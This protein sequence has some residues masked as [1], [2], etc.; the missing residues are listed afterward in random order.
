MLSK[1]DKYMMYD[2]NIIQWTNNIFDNNRETHKIFKKP[3]EKQEKKII[4]TYTKID[5]NDPL[6]MSFFYLLNGEF[7]YISMHNE[8]ST[9]KLE[10]INL[11]DKL[12]ANKDI[13]KKHKFKLNIIED[14]LLNCNKINIQTLMCLLIIHN[15]SFIIK[16]DKFYWTYMY[17]ENNINIIKI[18]NENVYVFNQIN[19]EEEIK[20]IKE[21]CIHCPQ[22][23][24]KI[25]S[26]S[27]YKMPELRN[28]C[29]KLN[30]STFKSD[31][32]KK[33]KKDIYQ[34]IQQFI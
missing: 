7:S 34:S 28:M 17:D 32:K 5:K 10:K 4:E 29:I 19:N 33:N 24:K 31:G 16:E 26:I 12:R 3:I 18:E 9:E 22:Y 8:F 2:K 20:H 6:Y 30:I 11:I 15:M 25:K 23:N 1:L 27:N 13:L 21:K 14:I